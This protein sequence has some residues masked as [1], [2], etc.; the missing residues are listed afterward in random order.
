MDP[1]LDA[2]VAPNAKA[3]LIASGFGLS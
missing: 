3:E 2:L 1:A